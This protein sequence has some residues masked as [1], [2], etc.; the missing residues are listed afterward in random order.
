MPAI[1]TDKPSI[2][3]KRL[4]A[5]VMPTTH[6]KVIGISIS[7]LFV[8]DAL[9]PKMMTNQ[10]A[11]IWAESFKNGEMLFTSSHIPIAIIIREANKAESS[12][13]LNE[14]NKEKMNRKAKAMDRPPKSGI[15]SICIFLAEGRST[16][17]HFKASLLI[18]GVVIRAQ[19][20]EARK[21]DRYKCDFIITYNFSIWKPKV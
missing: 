21:M 5:L 8:K 18:M 13:I 16:T 19:T 15:G 20:R 9:V 1:P 10:Q 6:K 17:P 7:G 11:K 3:S 12:S 14:P 4:K 2:L